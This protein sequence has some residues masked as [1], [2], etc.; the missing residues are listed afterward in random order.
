MNGQSTGTELVLFQNDAEGADVE[1]DVDVVALA[2]RFLELGGALDDG[3][4]QDSLTS[5]TVPPFS[6]RL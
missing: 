4:R 2:T 6:V 5:V 3:V 1:Q